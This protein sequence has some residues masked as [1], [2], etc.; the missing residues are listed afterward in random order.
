MTC[1]GAR[2]R[3]GLSVSIALIM[4]CSILLTLSVCN[5]MV[6][7]ASSPQDVL[8]YNWD[9]QGSDSGVPTVAE[10]ELVYGLTLFDGKEYQWTF[11]PQEVRTLYVISDT[12]NAIATKRAKVHFWPITGE[13][14]AD[15]ESA[16][17]MLDFSELSMEVLLGN[18]VIATLGPQ[19]YAMKYPSGH[20]GPATEMLLG[21]EARTE[22]DSYMIGLEEYSG[23]M[24]RYYEAYIEYTKAVSGFIDN[25]AA[26][27]GKIPR[28][29]AEPTP[30]QVCLSQVYEAFIVDVPEGSYRIRLKDGEGNVVPG[31]ERTMIAFSTIDRGIGYQIIP[32]DKWTYPSRSD[33][34]TQN[35]AA[36]GNQVI[37]VKPY[38]EA[39]FNRHHYTKLTELHR[40]A[41]GRG[42]ENHIAWIHL[43]PL[44]A[45]DE[46]F[47]IEVVGKKG[48]VSRAVEKPYYVQ[49][50]SGSSLG[51]NI[52]GFSSEAFPDSSPSFTAFRI[53]TPRNPGRYR[54]QLVDESRQALADSARELRTVQGTDSAWVFC[55][56]FIPFVVGA[57]VVVYK[58]RKSGTER[59]RAIMSE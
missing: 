55:V 5:T 30:P 58:R 37:Y 14:V 46:T 17:D 1:M 54:L 38:E 35:I 9:I 53:E 43:Q 27:D 52:I 41:S 8:T 57:C 26:F 23:A 13:Y 45:I 47:S 3:Q 24:N 31:S 16:T 49:Q 56:S 36:L 59:R 6:T 33:D 11:C 39:S 48:V 20:M 44:E 21:E 51:Y 50:T 12:K 2:R 10:Q 19:Q 42:M 22:Y 18:K 28:E 15:W 4:L 7:V 32:E 34:T 40:P 29:P 25:P